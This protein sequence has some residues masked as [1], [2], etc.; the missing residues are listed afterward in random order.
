MLSVMLALPASGPAPVPRR[1]PL[2]LLELLALPHVVVSLSPVM[3]HPAVELPPPLP[4]PM[5]QV[6]LVLHEVVALSSPDSVMD[7][8]TLSPAPPE[9]EGEVLL[10]VPPPEYD[11]DVSDSP[12]PLPEPL[13]VT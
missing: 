2:P 8:L 3:I 9:L 12:L 10:Y 6:E 4:V 1:V 11:E 7:P 13:T 5:P